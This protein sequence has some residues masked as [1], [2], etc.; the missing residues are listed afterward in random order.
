V[1]VIAQNTDFAPLAPR[2]TRYEVGMGAEV[3]A[4]TVQALADLFAEMERR[5]KLLATLPGSPPA[6]FR[7]LANKPALGLHPL[8]CVISGCHELFGHPTHGAQAAKL[9]ISVIKQG[10]KFGITLI[11]DTQSPTAASIPT[12][13]THNVSCGVAFSVGDHDANDGLLGSGRYRAGIR[14]TELRMH[15]DRGTCV[16]V[17]VSDATFELI[18]TFY[19]P[20]ADG[21]DL[22]TPVVTRAMAAI[23]EL[24]R[25]GDPT[26]G[27]DNHDET[28]QIDHLVNIDEVLRGERRVRTQV[29]LTR[30]AELHPAI[31]EGWTFSDLTAT[32][33]EYGIE[34]VKS[35]GLKV[36]RAADVIHA[37]THR[38]SS[39]STE[40]NHGQ[41]T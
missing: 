24:R 18:N 8:I 41:G 35:G 23:D 9:A 37:L 40:G 30:L 31:Y 7:K 34:P 26:T 20:Y 3:A 13:V 38:D 39:K 33:A 1:F 36:V 29:V 19:V 28:K 14:A 17:G 22:V 21:I 6:T 2:L 16:A 32:L 25:T 4:A 11:L 15:T 10:R 5:G 27:D 12:D